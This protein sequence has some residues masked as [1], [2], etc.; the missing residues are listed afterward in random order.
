MKFTK[1]H[2]IGNDYVYVNCFE[3]SVKN[4]AE[5]SKFVS[6]R[7]FGIGSDGLILISP[8]AIADFRMNIYNAD[9]SQAEM[10]GN[11]IRCVAKY[12]YDYGL[13]DKTE[14]SVET[15]AG[16][17]YLRLQV[18]N[19]KVASV[20]VNMGAPIL[21]SKEIPV[22]VEESPVVNVP[23]EV[24]GKI[25][26]M[27]CVSM[28]N[29]HAIIFMNNVKDLDIEAIGPYFENH[30]VFP[31]RTNTEFVEVLD[32]NTVNMRVWERGSDETL[33]CG[34]GACATTVACILNDK[35]EN[36]VTVHL[37][38]GD[39]KIRWDRE[40]NQVYMTGPA[41]VVFDGEIT[42]PDGIA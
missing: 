4:P 25:Y 8:S 32:R 41:T 15:L 6:D 17:K 33:A 36:E 31:K 37:L 23:V 26:H 11:G 40:A 7:H 34:T 24:K 13:T 21:E 1:M 18:E 16:I 20:E 35:T 22:A 19:G 28:G 12:V 29:P 42:L 9:G 5:V 2:G 27:T 30:T 14:I 39:L 3:E 38:G 10:C